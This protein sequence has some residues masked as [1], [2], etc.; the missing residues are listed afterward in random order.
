MSGNADMPSH[1]V[2]YE[3]TT[4]RV[5]DDK[6]RDLHQDRRLQVAAFDGEQVISAQVWGT[7]PRCGHDINIKPIL[8]ALVAGLRGRG[9]WATLTG[10]SPHDRPAIPDEV[11][12]GCGCGRI[13][14]QAPE[15]PDGTGKIAGC[16]V[17]F[18][19]PTT[20]PAASTSPDVP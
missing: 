5:W 4:G 16:G 12:V 17:S 11:E 13:H 14:P 3:N 1:D 6:A 15:R 20:P 9:L 2:P 10:R 7:C 19:L 8:T 18:R